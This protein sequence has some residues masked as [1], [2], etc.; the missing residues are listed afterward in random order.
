LLPLLLLLLMQVLLILLLRLN[1]ASKSC[2]FRLFPQHCQPFNGSEP[3]QKRPYDSP[4]F[5]H[6]TSRL[7]M[8]LEP[9]LL[10]AAFTIGSATTT[11][12][13]SRKH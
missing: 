1:T 2:S 9:L 6:T 10:F 7:Y 4:C 13:T 8:L 3:T 11:T 12:T 5:K